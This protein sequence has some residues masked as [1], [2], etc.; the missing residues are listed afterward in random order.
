MIDSHSSIC[1]FYLNTDYSCLLIILYL[2][3]IPRT[4]RY[5]YICVGN[6]L[7]VVAALQMLFSSLSV[8]NTIFL[9]L[10]ILIVVLDNVLT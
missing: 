10:S 4:R 8:I 9:S 1:F 2:S 6:K 7:H 5:S 3:V